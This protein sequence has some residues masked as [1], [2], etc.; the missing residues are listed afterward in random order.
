MCVLTIPQKCGIFKCSHEPWRLLNKCLELGGGQMII[1]NTYYS[2]AVRSIAFVMANGMLVTNGV[3]DEGIYDFSPVQHV[4][5]ITPICGALWINGKEFCQGATYKTTGQGKLVIEARGGPSS[6]LCLYPN[7][8]PPEVFLSGVGILD[9]SDEIRRT[10]MHK[11]GDK[12]MG[13]LVQMSGGDIFVALDS[14]HSA[15]ADVTRALN[16]LNMHSG[17][18][19]VEMFLW[20]PPKSSQITAM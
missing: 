18:T 5:H 12:N 3:V 20:T 17:M 11:F 6:Y 16:E 13:E 15:S 14:D 8:K 19:L 2:G 10:L 4:E 1:A 7:R 9:V